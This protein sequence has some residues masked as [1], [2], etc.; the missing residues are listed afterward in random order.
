MRGPA[1][2]VGGQKFPSSSSQYSFKGI[3]AGNKKR[4]RQRSLFLISTDHYAQ[5]LP[6]D[7]RALSVFSAGGGGIRRSRPQ[8]ANVAMNAPRVSLRSHTT[9][10]PW[11][12]KAS[13]SANAGM[14]PFT[15]VRGG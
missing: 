15:R 10:R 8:R 14:A 3:D 13:S 4:E 11:P 6:Q 1:P 7:A 9:P 2:R 5:E 12:L